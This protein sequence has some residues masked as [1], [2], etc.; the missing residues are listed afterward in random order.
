MELNQE[1]CQL[2][3]QPEKKEKYD[4][5]YTYHQSCCGNTPD[6]CGEVKN[7]WKKRTEK[8]MDVL[9]AIEGTILLISGL[10][11][12]ENLIYLIPY[13]LAAAVILYTLLWKRRWK[14]DFE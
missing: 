10:A 14:L 3:V 12:C 2:G 9:L 6:L 11:A 13:G 7:R 8:L 1:D 4:A 5:T